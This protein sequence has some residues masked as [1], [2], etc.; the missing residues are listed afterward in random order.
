VHV[1]TIDPTSATRALKPR[2][3]ACLCNAC[4]R[5]FTSV[6]AFELHQR[7]TPDG[8]VVCRDPASV[9][10]CIVERGGLAWCARKAPTIRPVRQAAA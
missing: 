8:S 2:S 7:L 6:K 3:N 10:L 9:G 5:Y 4:R 1:I